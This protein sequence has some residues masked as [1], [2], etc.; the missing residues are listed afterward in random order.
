M[1][2]VARRAAERKLPLV[3]GGDLQAQTAAAR[4]RLDGDATA[5]D[6]W[7]EEWRCKWDLD[8]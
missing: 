4:E 8:S 6:L 7:L 2:T 3:V 5:Y 1:T